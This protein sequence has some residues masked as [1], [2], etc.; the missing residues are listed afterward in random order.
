VRRTILVMA[1]ALVV[2]GP[3]F[4]AAVVPNPT[5]EGPVTGGLGAP[6]L[7]GTTFDLAQVGYQEQEFFV[8][9]TASAFT[10][11]A[12]L[13]SDGLW[14]VTPGP[15]AAYKTRIVV[16]R[17]VNPKR[18]NGTV[19]VE[20]LNVSGGLDAAPDWTGAHTALIR[21]GF[22]WVGVSA[23]FVGVEGGAGL[24]GVVELPLKTVDPARYGSLVHPGDSFSYDIFSQVGQAIRHPAGV[25]VLGGLAVKRVLAAGESQSAFRMV[26]YV[27]GIHPLA[28]VYDGFLIHSRGAGGPFGAPLSEAPQAAIGTPFPT[29]IRTDLREPVLTFQTETDLTFLRS[30]L[31]RQPD[32]TH[33]RLW[34]VAGTSHA[35][36]YLIAQGPADLGDSPDVADLVLTSAPVP[37]VIECDSTINSGPQ[38]FV[39]NAAFVALD[40]WVRRGRPPRPAPRL[41]VDPGPPVTLRRDAHG[42]A[43]GGIRLPQVEVPIATFTG[44]QDGSILC[45]L[46]GTTTPF[47]GATLAAL[48]P[49]HRAFVSRFKRATRNAQ[50]MG[51]VLPH[52]A[53]LL[54]QWAAGADVGS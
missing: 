14:T 23:Q 15:T 53:R 43:L 51:F 10:S 20:W 26:T 8:S 47:D 44:E 2:A 29:L 50:R 19:V 18:F 38:H 7:Q 41:E 17:P 49:R 45:R 52:D 21:G 22:A 4:A 31:A 25:D 11:A 36:A 27:D 35:D 9:G 13:A 48:Y 28:R 32:T 3:R 34:E 37:G 42:N 30:D 40:R 24:V 39:L 33:L 16:H 54:R 6:F 12:P 1:L 46:F 5:V